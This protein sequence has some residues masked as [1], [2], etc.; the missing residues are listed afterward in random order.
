MST[1]P[2]IAS[3]ARVEA[4]H[5]AGLI[6][7]FQQV[8]AADDAASDEAVQRL[9]PNVYPDD[10]DASREF[11]DATSADLVD[12]RT[13]EARTVLAALQPLIDEDGG[14][15][16]DVEV[17][18]AYDDV[19]A[20]LRTFAALRLVLASRLGIELES[21]HAPGDQRF[22]IYDWLGYRLELLIEAADEID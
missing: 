16:D 20:W 4:H 21:D 18:I 11:A 8:L 22:G 14:D 1:P 10:A 15:L 7:Q 13:L 9:T 6:E 12:R 5:L 17:M 3:F 19:D 2:V